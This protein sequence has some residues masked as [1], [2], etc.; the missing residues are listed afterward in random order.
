MDS[1]EYDQESDTEDVYQFSTKLFFLLHIRTS[2]DV[3]GNIQQYANE[4]GL[5]SHGAYIGGKVRKSSTLFY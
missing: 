5:Q 1:R 4:I 2:D 3:V